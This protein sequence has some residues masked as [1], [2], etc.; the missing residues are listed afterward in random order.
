MFFFKKTHSTWKIK[1]NALNLFASN[2]AGTPKNFYFLVEKVNEK[3]L[4]ESPSAN[5]EAEIIIDTKEIYVLCFQ[6]G[7]GS[8]PPSPVTVTLIV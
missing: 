5:Y 2:S 1:S 3:D 6:G 4:V 8:G 7:G